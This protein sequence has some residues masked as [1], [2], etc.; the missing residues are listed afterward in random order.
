MV[1]EKVLIDLLLEYLLHAIQLLSDR[2]LSNKR[3]GC[4]D[5]VL[6]AS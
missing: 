2:F 5:I 4:K 6:I 3:N 1:T